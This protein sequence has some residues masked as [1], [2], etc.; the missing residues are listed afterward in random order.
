MGCVRTYKNCYSMQRTTWIFERDISK[1]LSRSSRSMSRAGVD[2]GSYGHYG[3]KSPT[4]PT[5]Y[6]T[7]KPCFSPFSPYGGRPIEVITNRKT[8]KMNFFLRRMQSTSCFAA[9]V[10]LLAP[11]SSRSASQWISP[12]PRFRFS[13]ALAVSGV[14][15][16]HLGRRF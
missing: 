8:P 11:G 5:V 6:P 2:V 7:A 3:R 13:V 15:P 16:S 14:N 12:C 4:V 9:S 10:A 1:E